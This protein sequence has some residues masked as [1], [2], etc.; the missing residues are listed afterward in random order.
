MDL[1]LAIQRGR[2]CICGSL[3]VRDDGYCAGY[4]PV[5]EEFFALVEELA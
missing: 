3:T 1:D 2:C 4:R 5:T